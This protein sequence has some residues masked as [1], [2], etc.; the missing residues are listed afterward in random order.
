MDFSLRKES[1]DVT[2][3]ERWKR[4]KPECLRAEKK[5]I[6]C[7]NTIDYKSGGKRRRVSTPWAIEIE[8]LAFVRLSVYQ[9]SL[10]TIAGGTISR[11]FVDLQRDTQPRRGDEHTE[12]E[13]R[14]GH[15]AVQF[16]P[17]RAALQVPRNRWLWC[18]C[19]QDV[20]KFLFEKSSVV[21][22]P[23]VSS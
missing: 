16:S 15:S 19:V 14:L 4:R 20:L 12:V 17:Q 6:A 9:P 7:S 2:R 3:S 1:P 21:F 22:H 13:E 11:A 10:N 5:A 18:R 8:L 23:L